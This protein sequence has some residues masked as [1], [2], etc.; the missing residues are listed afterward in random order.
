MTNGIVGATPPLLLH[1]RGRTLLVATSFSFV[2]MCLSAFPAITN[3]VQCVGVEL[4]PSCLDEFPDRDNTTSQNCL[5]GFVRGSIV[6][7]YISFLTPLSDAVR[8]DE[9]GVLG[10]E[11]VTPAMTNT[12]YKFVA[13]AGFSNHVVCAYSETATNDTIYAMTAIRS[14]C[15]LM[16]KTNELQTIIK[17]SGNAWRIIQWDVDE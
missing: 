5:L 10:L 1:Q 13:S 3:I 12:F 2:M 9:F 11:D 4:T 17:Q 14:Q 8:M 16:V 6:G 15:G 7:D